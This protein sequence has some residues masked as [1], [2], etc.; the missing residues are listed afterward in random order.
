MV[1]DPTFGGGESAPTTAEALARAGWPFVAD[2]LLAGIVHDLNGRV[3]SLGGMIQLL[4][5]GDEA[6]GVVPF[7]EEEVARL[8]ASVKL[9]SLLA[10]EPDPEP[11]PLDVAEL[12]PPLLELHRRHRGM[13]A[14]DLRLELAASPQVV[15]AWS[16]FG[17][18][19]LMALAAAGSQALTRGHRLAI[20]AD[21]HEDG[22][23]LL[24]L[25]APGEV[26]APLAGAA[27]HAAPD[28][29]RLIEV[30]ALLPAHMTV[31]AE[32]SAFR[33]KIHVPRIHALRD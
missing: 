2:R 24:D 26:E 20:R 1:D 28:P 8:E 31:H 9:V 17:R 18:V 7:L 3:T 11:E 23:L 14:V 16:L 6:G 4:A 19:L 5:L 27:A 10:G 22:G 25:L 33:L 21:R 30:A 12:L 32:P 29:D 15:A 13:E